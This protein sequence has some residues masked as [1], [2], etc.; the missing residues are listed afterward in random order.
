MT[1]IGERIK[2]ATKKQWFWMTVWNI[3][4][5]LFVIWSGYYAVLILLL[6]FF[7][8]YITKIIPWGFWKKSKNPTV[9][10]TMEWVDAIVFALVAV[11]FINTFFFQNY[12]IPSSSLEKS[13]LVG[14]FLFVSKVNYGARSP[15]TPFSFPLV[16]HTFPILNIKSYLEKPQVEYKRL[17]GF[18]TVKRGD[19]VVFNFPAGD[20]VAVKKPE[21]DY[22]ALC[23]DNPAGRIGVWSNK[24]EYGDIVYRPVDR[25]ENYVKRCMGLPGETIELRDDLVYIDGNPVDDPHDM[26]LGYVVQTDGTMI[27]ENVF[28]ELEIT[29]E[30]KA[31]ISLLNK[32]IVYAAMSDSAMFI[33]AGFKP[34][35][36]GKSIFY[37]DIFLTKEKAEILS[38]KPFVLSV[39][40]QNGVTKLFGYYLRKSMVYP[41]MYYNNCS[42]GDFPPLWIPKRGETI[43]FD[44]SVDYKVAAYQRCIKNY[45]HNDFDYRDGKVYINGK[46]TDSYTFKYD[47]YFM[48]GDNRD[49]SADSRAWGFVPEDHV[50]GEP[51]FIWL[52]LD[53]DKGWF[54]G[55]IRFD[56][57]FRSA[58]KK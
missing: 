3:L 19:I 34:S 49:N 56:R 44:G 5:I 48:M 54:S 7:D 21:R 36:T 11:Y 2:N 38:K 27:S 29:N 35:S 37:Q 16:Q 4:T 43:T 51:L 14:D 15:M 23:A 26:Q 42:T 9:K 53:K 18:G 12:Q 24:A 33:S 55:K 57:I 20:T 52:S 17:A 13:L 31:R 1:N 22:Y 30:D 8:C 6:F 40:R 58:K 50:V 45:E 25:R 46:Q 28:D 10:K 32:D 41:I 39:S 47:Y